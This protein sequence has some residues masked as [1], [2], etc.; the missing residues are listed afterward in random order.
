M[1]VTKRHRPHGRRRRHLNEIL[2]RLTAARV[3]TRQRAW[4]F[5]DFHAG[6]L[7]RGRVGSAELHDLVI[8]APPV[9]RE[10][11]VGDDDRGFASY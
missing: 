5:D 11:Y 10:A 3:A 1:V 7:R 4:P 8:E 6:G 2:Q 9:I